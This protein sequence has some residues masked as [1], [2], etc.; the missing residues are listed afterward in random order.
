[1]STENVE[2]IAATLQSLAQY[3]IDGS[4]IVSQAMASVRNTNISEH[5][6]EIREECEKNIEELA[7]LICQYGREVPEHSRDFKGFFMQ[8]YTGMRGLVS[9]KGAMRAL[10]TNIG[11]VT[12]A[13]EKALESDLPSEVKEK[14]QAL[15]INVKDHLEYAA[16]QA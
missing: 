15:Y 2:D 10:Q 9:D 14:L 12:K 13:Y 7:E 4:F 3:E 8:G 5:L 16:S 6:S 1:M 11:L